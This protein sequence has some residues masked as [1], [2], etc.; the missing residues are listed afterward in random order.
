MTARRHEIADALFRAA[1]VR[2]GC[3]V[4]EFRTR[5]QARSGEYA[6]V[7]V[8]YCVWWLLRQRT[9]YQLA[10]IG[11]FT[12]HDHSTVAH[13]IAQVE[14]RK[15]L[16][17]EETIETLAELRQALLGF[18]PIA[19]QERY[20]E[21]RALLASSVLVAEQVEALGHTLIAAAQRLGEVAGEVERG[22]AAAARE[23]YGS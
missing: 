21:A 8:R 13:G 6:L 3:T 4:E 5:G 2:L 15:R 1:A 7:R 23:G 18:E 11:E 22:L 20:R 19:E 16:R 12:A 17:D 9:D 14:K 10:E